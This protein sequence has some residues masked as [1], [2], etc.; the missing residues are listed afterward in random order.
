V[1]LKVA[2]LPFPSA[3]ALRRLAGNVVA[4]HNAVHRWDRFAPKLLVSGSGALA[5]VGR[6]QQLYIFA[7]GRA[8]E[9]VLAADDGVWV[10]M[11]ALAQQLRGERLTTAIRKVKLWASESG[12]GGSSSTAAR[13]KRAMV[14]AG[15]SHVS[16]YGYTKALGDFTSGRHKVAADVDAA[17][18]PIATYAAKSVRVRF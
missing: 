15:F 2:Y 5:S 9:P 17:G 3:P 8:K 13:L 1:N 4:A 16:V 18:N 14:A 11:D 6:Y 10:D 7:L 12:A